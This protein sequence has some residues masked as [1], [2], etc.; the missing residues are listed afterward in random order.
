MSTARIRLRELITADIREHRPQDS[1]KADFIVDRLL[2]MP[3]LQ[4]DDN[5]IAFINSYRRAIERRS[6]TNQQ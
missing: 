2:E 5:V 6:R 4:S 1:D 3:T